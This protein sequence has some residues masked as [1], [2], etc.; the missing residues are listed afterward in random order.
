MRSKT[1]AVL[2]A[3]VI[4][5]YVEP[6]LAQ[7]AKKEFK[8]CQDCPTMVT[9]P[10]GAFNM[11]FS[12]KEE[13][14]Y[15]TALP[16]HKVTIG[17]P[18]AIGKYEV[19]QEEFEKVMGF[20]PSTR[21]YSPRH[22][23]ENLT[24]Y[25]ARQFAQK[26]SQITGHRYRLPSEAEWEYAARAGTDTAWYCGND[27][28]CTKQIAVWYYS[29]NGQDSPVGSKN[30]NKFGLHDMLGNISEMVE[31]PARI[32]IN[33]SYEGAPIDGSVWPCQ[34]N[35]SYKEFE[36]G[37]RYDIHMIRGGNWADDVWTIRS[38]N[39]LSQ[40]ASIPD[41]NTGFRVVREFP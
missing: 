2:T 11:G 15:K 19:T 38:A 35:P 33:G 5:I 6:S 28:K 7:P 17:K 36:G 34:P 23:V 10:A 13:N 30:P 1:Y 22:P 20:N 27:Y 16:K 4:A 21:K 39:R 24:L 3:F 29:R 41:S 32:A 37:C 40:A 12:P 31:D 25:Q 18:F 8:D 9:I 26:L 14:A